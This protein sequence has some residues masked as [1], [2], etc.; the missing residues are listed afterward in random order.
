MAGKITSRCLLLGIATPNQIG[1]EL[2]WECRLP[3]SLDACLP[4]FDPSAN[5]VEVVWLRS[6]RA[7]DMNAFSPVKSVR[8]AIQ[9]ADP[10]CFVTVEGGLRGKN[11]LLPCPFVLAHGC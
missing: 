2:G 6:G 4:P 1:C 8:V 10:F 5:M 3:A 11:W 9:I 7:H